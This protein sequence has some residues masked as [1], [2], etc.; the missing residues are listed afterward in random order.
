MSSD[1][2]FI[3]PPNKKGQDECYQKQQD[4]QS[5]ENCRGVSDRLGDNVPKLQC[6]NLSTP[7]HDIS[8]WSRCNYEQAIAFARRSSFYVL[9]WARNIV[10]NN[11]IWT[12][13]YLISYEFV[14]L[15][16]Q[17]IRA[18]LPSSSQD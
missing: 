14:C 16:C 17:Y 6:P 3:H 2:S 8:A 9:S 10:Y 13:I 15:V 18:I 12:T 11:P 1:K 7:L 4:A 5:S